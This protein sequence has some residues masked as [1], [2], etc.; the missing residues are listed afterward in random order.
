MWTLLAYKAA[1]CSVVYIDHVMEELAVSISTPKRGDM[2][3]IHCCENLICFELWFVTICVQCYQP[4]EG[5]WEQG[6][7]N[8][9]WTQEGWGDGRMEEVAQ[10]GTS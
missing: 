1:A 7:E 10:W 8:N 5:V 6:S 4:T 3:H 9:I 2:P